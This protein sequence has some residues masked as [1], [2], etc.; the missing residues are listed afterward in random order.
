MQILII[1]IL[2]FNL[3]FRFRMLRKIEEYSL[4]LISDIIECCKNLESIFYLHKLFEELSVL[5]KFLFYYF[6]SECLL[7]FGCGTEL[8]KFHLDVYTVKS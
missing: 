1:R 2:S 4:I 6:N 5:L 3:I 7:C 8:T